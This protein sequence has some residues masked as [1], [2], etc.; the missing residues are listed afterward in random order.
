MYNKSTVTFTA[1]GRQVEQK[2]FYTGYLP[3]ELPDAPEKED[4]V[5]TAKYISEQDALFA[6]TLYFERYDVWADINSF[7][8][9]YYSAYTVTP[10]DAQEKSVA[11]SVSDESVAEIDEKGDGSHS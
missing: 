7:A 9:Q 3:E 2:V 11:W 1:D 5:I 10:D 4:A 6:D 8:N